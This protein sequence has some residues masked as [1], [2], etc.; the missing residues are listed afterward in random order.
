[1]FD[2]MTQRSVVSWTALI[3][4]YSR[5]G[6]PREALE[7]FLEMRRSGFRANQF[8]FGSVMRA[9]TSVMCVQVGKQIQGCVEKSRFCEDLFVQSAFVDFHSKCGKME[10]AWG[11]FERM[12]RKDVVSWNVLIGGYA[13]Q[14]LGADAFD[15]FCSMLRDGMAKFFDLTVR[16]KHFEF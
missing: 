11:V 14:G 15:M 7:V 3:S 16:K 8:T 6:Y 9:C 13:V 10:D 12:S 1:M 2:E 5:N 4:G